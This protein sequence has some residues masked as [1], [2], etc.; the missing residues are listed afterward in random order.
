MER[1][2]LKEVDEVQ[3]DVAKRRSGHR[4]AENGMGSWK[5]WD[6]GMDIKGMDGG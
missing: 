2:Q 5:S 6:S 4:L 1:K 3:E